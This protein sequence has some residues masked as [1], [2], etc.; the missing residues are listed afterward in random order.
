MSCDNILLSL[1][2]YAR[3]FT[4]R[5]KYPGNTNPVNYGNWNIERMKEMTGPDDKVVLVAPG[6]V[7]P[8]VDPVVS[9]QIFSRS[10]LFPLVA[11]SQ[12][13][14]IRHIVLGCHDFYAECQQ[15]KKEGRCFTHFTTV[16]LSCCKSCEGLDFSSLLL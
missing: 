9:L 15:W 2:L 5:S 7:R 4:H 3:L 16:V 13:V 6:G 8:P 12:D 11:L 10:N 14:I 1:N